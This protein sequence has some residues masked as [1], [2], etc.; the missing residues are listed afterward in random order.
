MKYTKKAAKETVE[1]YKDM[2]AY[3]D[4]SMTQ[5]SMF[6][7]LKYRM[8]FGEAE[9]RVIIGALVIAGAKFKN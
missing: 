2:T 6:E 4:G 5:E 8:G 9:T 3:F 1:A 7:M